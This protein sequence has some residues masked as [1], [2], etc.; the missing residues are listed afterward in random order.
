MFEAI[1]SR[2]VGAW[3]DLHAR[4]LPSLFVFEFVV[5]LLGVLAAQWVADWARERQAVAEMEDAKTKAEYQIGVSMHTLETWGKLSPCLED[6][7]RTVM[8]ANEDQSPVDPRILDRPKLM[9]LELRPLTAQELLRLE[10]R[11][12]TDAEFAFG[13]IARSTRTYEDRIDIIQEA[14]KAFA[15]IDP[16]NGKPEKADY[17]QARMAAS[18]ILAALRGLEIN[19]ENIL[20]DARR[21]NLAP[22]NPYGG[23][24]ASSCEEYWDKGA[25]YVG[26]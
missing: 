2:L 21:L 25:M 8:R 24:P 5:V 6:A 15:Q 26:D 22:F 14:W 17:Q 13:N 12:G 9:G 3:K 4:G 20:R 11:Y 16:S 18:G 10:K 1:R 7:M 23:R 19:R